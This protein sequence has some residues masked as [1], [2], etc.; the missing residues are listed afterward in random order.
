[1]SNHPARQSWDTRGHNR[2][3]NDQIAADNTVTSERASVQISRVSGLIS[4]VGAALLGSLT[5]RRSNLFLATSEHW[6]R[7]TL[8]YLVGT[9]LSIT[10]IVSLAY[11]LS[12]GVPPRGWL[13]R[14]P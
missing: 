13:Q 1:M 8:A 7:N 2:A 12:S 11:L 14:H 3:T 9:A 5:Q 10:L 6:P 4:Q